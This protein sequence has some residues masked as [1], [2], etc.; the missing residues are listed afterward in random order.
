MMSVTANGVPVM[1]SGPDIPIP[2]FMMGNAPG[3]GGPAMLAEFLC[4]ST[5]PSR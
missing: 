5:Y 2:D 4:M 1:V 3:M